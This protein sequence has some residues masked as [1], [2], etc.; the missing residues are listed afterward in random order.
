MR[1]HRVHHKYSDT[2]IDPH[3]INRG[4]FY[5]H[6]GWLLLKKQP[7]IIEAGKKINMDDILND[8][9]CKIQNFFSPLWNQFWCFGFPSLYG[10][11]RFSE[12][13]LIM[14]FWYGYL[15]FGVLRWILSL[16]GTWCVNSVAHTFVK[17]KR[18][19]NFYNFLILGI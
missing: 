5:S 18:K 7:E 11:W 4:F 8:P 10:M 3:N 12:H 2:D 6:M 19:T 15:I 17:L 16:H 14:G 9:V 1:D 13:G